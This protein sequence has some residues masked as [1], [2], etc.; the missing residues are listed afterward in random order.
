MAQSNNSTV[1][2]TGRA[3]PSPIW[4]MQPM[5][6]AATIAAPVLSTART[7]RA[8]SL[9]ADHFLPAVQAGGEEQPWK[10]QLDVSIALGGGSATTPTSTMTLFLTDRLGGTTQYAGSREQPNAVWELEQPFIDALKP[11]LYGAR[12]PGPA[13][14]RR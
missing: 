2:T 4:V 5:L 6:P 8:R 7:L 3:V 14:E 11:L 1:C 12:D 13:P 9:V 10:Y